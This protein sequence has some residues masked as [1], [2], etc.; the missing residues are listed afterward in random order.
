MT[1]RARLEPGTVRIVGAGNARRTWSTRHVLH[2]RLE[3]AGA[4]GVGEA[5]PLP[6]YSPDALEAAGEA[7]ARWCAAPPSLDVDAP[8][9]SARRAS[10]RIPSALPSARFAA[11]TAVLDLL[12]RLRGEPLH[13]LLVGEADAATRE[14]PPLAGLVASL[15]D[16]E[17]QAVRLVDRGLGTLKL[18]VGRAERLDDEVEALE[19]LRARW[20]SVAL[21]LDANGALPPAR[22]DEL[23][24]RYAAVAPE[25]VEEPLAG[26]ALRRLHRPPVPLAL[27]ESLQDA[28]P[29]TAG[30]APFTDWLAEGRCVAVVLKP[31]ALGGLLACLELARAAARHRVDGRAVGAIASHTFDG[32]VG[33]Q[34]AAAL[35][36]ALALEADRPLAAGLDRS[37]LPAAAG[38]VPLVGAATLRPDRARPGL[39]LDLEPDP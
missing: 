38:E 23:L 28:G 9:Q 2:L 34:A 26:A 39:G 8:L 22:V 25:L 36:L 10:E 11:E 7:L 21:R 13:R 12:G 30:L 14:P 37:Y 35:G 17:E 15:D 24:E 1:P 16:A 27:D 33:L 18:K 6:G 32:P 20:P 29:G 3:A 31:A 5:A 4:A 19:R